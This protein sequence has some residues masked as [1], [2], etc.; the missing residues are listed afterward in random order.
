MGDKYLLS[1]MI[2][3][4]FVGILSYDRY[5]AS[6][7]EISPV[8]KL[9]DFAGLSQFADALGP[10]AKTKRRTA[11][12]NI[13]E[14]LDRLSQRYQEV[15]EKRKELMYR[16]SSIL[17]ELAA[18]II[19]GQSD[20]LQY[21]EIIN[22]E[23]KKL[24]EHFPELEQLGKDM[25]RPNADIT[26]IDFAGFKARLIGIAEQAEGKSHEDIPALAQ[27]LKKLET[28]E[29]MGIDAQLEG[30]S[31]VQ[32]CLIK[33]IQQIES[34]AMASF[35]EGAAQP[36][37]DIQDLTSLTDQLKKES[38][39]LVNNYQAT[40]AQ[41][42]QKEIALQSRLK[43]LTE[44]LVQV[45]EADLRE[46]LQLYTEIENEEKILSA[47]LELNR[48]RLSAIFADVNDRLRN[49]Q[50][51]LGTIIDPQALS[52]FIQNTSILQAKRQQL[53]SDLEINGSQAGQL[54][55][56]RFSESNNLLRQFLQDKN[57]NLVEMRNDYA[58][59]QQQAQSVYNLNPLRP[60]NPSTGI[61]HNNTHPS[62]GNA[63]K[64]AP[65]RASPGLRESQERNKVHTPA[66]RQMDQLRQNAR[67]QGFYN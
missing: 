28:I 31:D 57:E 43:I 38:N 25:F 59:Q 30:C 63:K 40:E 48:R 13:N 33:D 20:A 49:V 60:V 52:A 54:L 26:T 55:Q 1:M 7:G 2:L 51:S 41:L 42:E 17:Q 36:L 18:I 16:R 27:I 32:A 3:F 9:I 37:Q 56:S 66:N 6:T 29:K 46:L 35:E 44:A 53:L 12:F 62:P 67:N 50:R 15:E 45:T 24:Q 23:R 58:A 64:P 10:S 65:F 61:S 19:D 4:L 22:Q 5:I 34:E 11:E 14:R 21:A 8:A 47:N 39:L